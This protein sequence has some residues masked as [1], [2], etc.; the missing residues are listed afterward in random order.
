[1]PVYCED[2]DMATARVL[3]VLTVPGYRRGPS[4]L[5]LVVIGLLFLTPGFLAPIGLLQLVGGLW[6]LAALLTAVR[7]VLHVSA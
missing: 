2:G 5:G 6:V 1:M 4:V 7:D 3:D